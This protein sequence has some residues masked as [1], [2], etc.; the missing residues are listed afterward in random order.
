MA[1]YEPLTAFLERQERA[2][3]AILGFRAVP[4]D[5]RIGVPRPLDEQ[6]GTGTAVIA[7]GAGESVAWICAPRV[8]DRRPGHTR[9]CA[10]CRCRKHPPEARLTVLGPLL[11]LAGVIVGAGLSY[12]FTTIG[13]TRRER[14][15]LGREWRERKLPPAMP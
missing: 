7:Y 10:M 11:A 15:A 8:G 2:S 3:I 13:E 14:W 9:C 4:R 5:S 1:K 6:P 12:V